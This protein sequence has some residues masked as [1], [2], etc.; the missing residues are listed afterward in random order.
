[1]AKKSKFLVGFLLLGSLIAGCSKGS[2][3]THADVS[4][5]DEVVTTN[6]GDNLTVAELYNYVLENQSDAI[7]KTVL[8]KILESKLDLNN[9]S[10]QDM[11]N[12]YKKYLNEYFKTTFVD[13]DTYKF[14]GEFSEDLLVK[15]LKSESYSIKC[16]SG[17]NAGDLDATTFACDYSDYIEK[18]VNYDIYVKMLK[19]KYLLN[20]KTDLINK[21]NGRRVVYYTVAKGSNDNEVRELLE[22]YVKSFEENKESTDE[23]VIKNIEDVAEAKRKKDLEEVSEHYAYVST[24]QDSS[25]GY[26]YL[27]KFTKCGDKRCSLE[28]GKEYQ[29]KLIMDKEYYTTKVVISSNT[30]VLYAGARDILFSD[31]VNDYLY[32]IGNSKYLMSPAYFDDNDKRINDIILYDAAN[33]NYYLATVETINSSSSFDDKVAVA[34]L[35]LDKVTDA[36]IFNYCYENLEIEIFDKDIREYFVS[37]YGDTEVE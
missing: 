10:N 9:T 19:I 34:E 12:L 20:E 13:N 6:K 16:G 30:D 17:F 14:N 26:T 4:F 27:D 24:S 31:N 11:K 33:S 2:V 3:D 8:V 1:M 37:K 36:I 28:E 32:Q 7:A 15:Y 18:E 21:S 29:D 5:G 22:T 23:T 25:S 35:L